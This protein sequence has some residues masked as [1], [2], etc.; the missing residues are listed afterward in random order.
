MLVA[1]KPLDRSK[2]KSTWLIL[3]YYIINACIVKHKDP[4]IFDEL[5]HEKATRGTQ[6][7]KTG[8]QHISEGQRKGEEKA[9]E[10]RN[11]NKN[12]RNTTETV[13]YISNGKIFDDLGGRICFCIDLNIWMLQP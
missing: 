3:H 2:N 7:N 6:R 11:L 13:R 9:N 10:N 12:E 1:I 4:P 8:D 5:V